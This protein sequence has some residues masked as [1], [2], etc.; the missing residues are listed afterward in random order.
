MA[1]TLAHDL[2]VVRQ[3]KRRLIDVGVVAP[4]AARC[5]ILVAAG[6]KSQIL[7]AARFG[8]EFGV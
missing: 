4:A 3:I 2:S 8:H 5:P 1:A 6:G 7:F